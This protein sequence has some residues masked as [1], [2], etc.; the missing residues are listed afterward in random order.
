VMTIALLCSSLVK[1][2]T[3][4]VSFCR[5]RIGDQFIIFGLIPRSSL[6]RFHQPDQTAMPN[7]QALSGAWALLREAIEDKGGELTPEGGLMF[8]DGWACTM[9]FEFGGKQY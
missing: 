2:K 6:P 5:I 8:A 4:C 7:T 1:T 3:P 9:E